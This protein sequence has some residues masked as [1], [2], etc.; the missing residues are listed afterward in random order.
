MKLSEARVFV[1]DT[2]TTGI[3]LDNDRIVELGA[4]YFERGA[5]LQ[6]RRMLVN[7]GRPIPPEA[8]AVHHI[9]DED[10]R[11][12]SPFAEVG[13]RFVT[14]LDGSALGGPA[15]V[16]CG[17]N[18]T[19]FDAPLLNAELA[20]I[21]SAVRIDPERV[22]D[23][24]FFALWHLRAL[25]SRKL[26]FVCERFGVRLVDAHSAAADAVATGEVL[27][28]M[29]REGLVPDDHDDA[30]RAQSALRELL[31]LEWERWSYWLYEDRESGVLRMGAGKYCGAPVAEVDPGYFA[32]LVD[33]IGDLPEPVREIFAERAR[34]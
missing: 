18:A 34:G 8:T 24:F 29:I 6:R 25:R 7:P 19:R 11:L 30:L 32:F 2:E 1:F 16:L 33:K 12:A 14:H 20:R 17:Y 22:V 3:D 10:V 23:P 21:G 4:A 28:A 5:R 13:P 9:S 31:D 26:V 15:P 27:F